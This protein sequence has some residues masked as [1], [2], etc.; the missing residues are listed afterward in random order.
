[1]HDEMIVDLYKKRDEKAITE[2]SRKYG[3]KLKR[4]S[5]NIIQN[6]SDAEECENDTYLAAWN[7]IPP[8]SPQT[9]FFS[10]LAKI[11]RNIS[12]NLYN[13]NHTKKRYANVVR[14]SKEMEEC[15]PSPNDEV[16]KITENEL[17]ESISTF[18][19][20]LREEERNV[21]VTRYWYSESIKKIANTFNISESKTK[22]MLMRTR[23]KLRKY[24]ESEGLELWEEKIYMK[25]LLI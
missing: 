3:R 4:I 1:M 13:R 14:L 6:I 9:Y 25:R 16:C 5:F 15:I 22:S 11:I 19:K 20:T 10:Y 21:F 7:S 24:F 12:I 17:T 23:N 2:T 18:L 8:K